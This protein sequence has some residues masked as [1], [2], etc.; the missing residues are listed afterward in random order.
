M[1]FGDYP[2][3]IAKLHQHELDRKI[4]ALHA[5]GDRK[6]VVALMGK[7]GLFTDRQAVADYLAGRDE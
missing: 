4:E 1:S 6:G 3:N 2:N 5:A 7:Y